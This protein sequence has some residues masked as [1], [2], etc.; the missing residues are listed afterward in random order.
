MPN[1]EGTKLTISAFQRREYGWIYDVDDDHLAKINKIREKTNIRRQIWTFWDIYI[2]ATP[3]RI[4][5]CKL[6]RNRHFQGYLLESY[7]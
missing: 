7:T 1:T 2:Q 6:I 3:Q 4:P 5:P